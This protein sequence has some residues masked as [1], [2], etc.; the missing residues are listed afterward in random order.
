MANI[1]LNFTYVLS[2]DFLVAG[3]W[4]DWEAAEGDQIIHLQKIGSFVV[5][6]SSTG[7]LQLFGI[8]FILFSFSFMWVLMLDQV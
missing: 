2:F 8:N 7:Q 3:G 6:F 1:M 5:P 4:W